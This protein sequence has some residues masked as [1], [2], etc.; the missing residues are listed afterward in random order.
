[1]NSTR[2]CVRII[3][4]HLKLVYLGVFIWKIRCKICILSF[5]L[6]DICIIW[7]CLVYETAPVSPKPRSRDSLHV[8]Q[9]RPRLRSF[10]PL[11]P[12]LY[13]QALRY[14]KGYR[15]FDQERQSMKPVW[16]YRALNNMNCEKLI[17]QSSVW[18]STQTLI[19]ARVWKKESFH[20]KTVDVMGY[21]KILYMLNSHNEFS[22][23]V[24]IY[25]VS[26]HTRPSPTYWLT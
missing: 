6:Q 22:R 13:S 14:N 16:S 12:H 17:L 21:L 8:L 11:L 19:R 1:M 4:R 25:M 20:N 2:T 18:E 10:F 7:S 9:A 5:R 3:N 23:G 15:K 24:S 26:D